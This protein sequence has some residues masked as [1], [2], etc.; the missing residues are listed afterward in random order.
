[1][2][3]RIVSITER[4]LTTV[5]DNIQ[6][7]E[8]RARGIP[9]SHEW[10]RDGCDGLAEQHHPGPM[11]FSSRGRER[12]RL[13]SKQRSMAIRD[14]IRGR[15]C[16]YLEGIHWI[17]GCGKACDAVCR[18]DLDWEIAPCSRTGQAERMQERGADVNFAHPLRLV[19]RL[20]FALCLRA[21]SHLAAPETW[22]LS[23]LCVL[24]ELGTPAC[25]P[26]PCRA[27][28][29]CAPMGVPRPVTGSHP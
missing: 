3:D 9:D 1:M 15:S 16:H 12:L 29:N 11:A 19:A 22:A 18:F 20:I 25:T 23:L 24:C 6:H 8:C 2:A 14:L 5:V 4:N 10:D 27:C 17:W 26:T 13:V 28:A 7:V 21:R